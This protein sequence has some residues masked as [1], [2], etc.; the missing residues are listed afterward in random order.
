MAE[1][2]QLSPKLLGYVLDKLV[3]AL[4]IK[5]TIQLKNLPRMADFAVWGEAISRA[6]GYK[7]MEFINA[8]YD[9]IGKQNISAIDAHPSGLALLAEDLTKFALSLTSFQIS[10]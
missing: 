1:F 8:Y 2:D 6:M 3:K 7:E 9:N 4:Q 10:S 5:N